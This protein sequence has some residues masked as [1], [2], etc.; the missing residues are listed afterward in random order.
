MGIFHWHGSHPDLEQKT[1]IPGSLDVFENMI[2]F[3]IFN[4][5]LGLFNYIF[6]QFNDSALKINSGCQ[7]IGASLIFAYDYGTKINNNCFFVSWIPLHLYKDWTMLMYTGSKNDWN[8]KSRP[9]PDWKFWA[10][11]EQNYL[12]LCSLCC[13]WLIN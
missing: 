7:Y 3:P 13:I 4:V 11:C 2:Y 10:V 5:H 1:I 9:G 8:F 12:C 6:S